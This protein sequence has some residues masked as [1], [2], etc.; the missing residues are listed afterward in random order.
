VAKTDHVELGNG[1]RL[2]I[3]YE[4]RAVLALDKPPGWMLVPFTWQR[5]DRN[6]HAALESSLASGAFW[7]RS[8]NLRFLRHI[9]RLDSETSGILLFARSRGALETYGRL[10]ESRQMEKTYLAVVTGLPKTVN[11][12]CRLALGPDPQT[13]GR[14]KVDARNGK[15][16][17]TDFRVLATRTDRRYG[18]LALIEALPFTGRTHQI[19]VH[20]AAVG[21]PVLGD[22]LYGGA[23]A[24]DRRRGGVEPGAPAIPS[25]AAF[26]L[27]L[28]AVRLAYRDPF[29]Q[30]PVEILAPTEAFLREFGF[31]AAATTRRAGSGI[32]SSVSGPQTQA[33]R[34][35][36]PASP[37]R[38]EHHSGAPSA[39]KGDAGGS[40]N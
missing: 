1:E 18:P 12:T 5:T 9:H 39:R 15:S 4:D 31:A 27:A 26:P 19:R 34:K 17:E 40:P 11:W 2:A 33:S 29:T 38:H 25:N 32:S 37:L 24:T 16:A 13:I 6:L 35:A 10:F 28:R 14:M 21:H 8:R 3:L 22:P 7:A 30:R 20:L 36:V 23:G